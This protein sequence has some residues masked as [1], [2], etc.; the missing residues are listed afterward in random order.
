[1]G[2]RLV[3]INRFINNMGFFNPFI[4]NEVSFCQTF[5]K[6]LASEARK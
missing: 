1:M 4:I 2:V 6:L 5:I 3:W